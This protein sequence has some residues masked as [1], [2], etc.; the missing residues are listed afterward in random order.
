MSVCQPHAH[1]RR[2][3]RRRLWKGPLPKKDAATQVQSQ[4]LGLES[5]KLTSTLEWNKRSWGDW[6]GARPISLPGPA[7]NFQGLVIRVVPL[8]FPCQEHPGAD[9]LG[10]PLFSGFVLHLYTLISIIPTKNMQGISFWIGPLIFEMLTPQIIQENQNLARGWAKEAS[11]SWTRGRARALLRSGAA[12][13][14]GSVAEPASARSCC[15]GYYAGD[16]V[17]WLRTNGVSTS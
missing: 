14:P 9:F 10:C 1:T 12:T 7:K 4:A 6:N 2:V 5:L 8:D 16:I 13:R 17:R 15:V 11:I 3:D